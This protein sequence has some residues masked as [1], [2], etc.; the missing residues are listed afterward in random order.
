MIQRI[1][2]LGEHLRDP[3]MLPLDSH[4]K[5]IGPSLLAPAH[6]VDPSLC[7]ERHTLRTRIKASIPESITSVFLIH[8][9]D[10][11]ALISQHQL[12]A[13]C[14]SDGRRKNQRRVRFL[15]LN[16]YHKV[17]VKLVA[18]AQIFQSLDIV[19]LDGSVYF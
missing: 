4:M 7:Q 1:T 3:I 16:I 11:Q 15:R 12:D 18:N 2:R 8:G 5:S 13:I 19:N 6:N 9:I 17:E 14:I 10:V